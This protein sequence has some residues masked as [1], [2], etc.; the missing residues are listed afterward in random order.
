MIGK[1]LLV[2]A[3]ASL[4]SAHKVCR[5]PLPPD[6]MIDI[7]D[8]CPN[9]YQNPNGYGAAP[10]RPLAPQELRLPPQQPPALPE[11][12]REVSPKV[13][14]P[15]LSPDRNYRFD[16][17]SDA[18]VLQNRT[19]YLVNMKTGANITVAENA[20][21]QG[22]GFNALGYNANDR[23]LYGL[24]G[25]TLIRILN[26]GKLSIEPVMDTG[27][28]AKLG[29]F[30]N[31][32]LLWLSQAGKKV[33]SIHLKQDKHY[34]TIIRN[35]EVDLKG[36]P[37]PK[38]WA[39]IAGKPDYLY[40]I[41][42]VPDGEDGYPMLMRFATKS[43]E[44]EEV[45]R[46]PG[47]RTNKGATFGAAVGTPNGGFYAMH[48]GNGRVLRLDINNAAAARWVSQTRPSKVNDA[49]R[50]YKQPDWE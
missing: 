40:A 19:L 9:L 17:S 22:R 45:Y 31:R 44:W 37:I 32:G 30:D 14:L 3:A 29:D 34:G 33:V 41:G 50:C 18:Y 42:V 28:N 7:R 21:P 35:H 11:Q 43:L 8:L 39:F 4:G 24:Q 20:S 16:C 15:T 6:C 1:S 49:T 23:F 13:I 38:D 10:E 46:V 5:H 12:P 48:N 47:I 25:R 26:D 27:I 36:F 2:L